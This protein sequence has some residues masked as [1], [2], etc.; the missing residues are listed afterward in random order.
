MIACSQVNVERLLRK[1]LE[2]QSDEGSVVSS[3]SSGSLSLSDDE[4]WEQIRKELQNVG[5]TPRAFDK[6]RTFILQTLEQ[7]ILE[8]DLLTTFESGSQSK[9]MAN[10]SIESESAAALTPDPAMIPQ[11]RVNQ[12]PRRANR[13]D[14]ISKPVTST[15]AKRPNRLSRLVYKLTTSRNKFIQAAADGDL[16]LVMHHLNMDVDVHYHNMDGESALIKAAG[17]GHKNI[18]ELL[19]AQGAPQRA[20]SG[21]S[22][23][24]NTALCRAAEK[25]HERIIELILEGGGMA[26]WCPESS[27]DRPASPLC[28]AASGGHLRAKQVLLDKGASVET[29]HGNGEIRTMLEHGAR[30]TINAIDKNQETPL[31]LAIT[32]G[33]SEAAK[34]L[35]EDGADVNKR[36]EDGMQP[37]LYAARINRLAIVQIL[38]EG[39]ADVK[40]I[41]SLGES[42]LWEAV[43]KNNIRMAELLLKKGA[44][45]NL[46]TNDKNNILQLAVRR[47]SISMASI[48]LKYKAN[49]NQRNEKGETSLFDAVKKDNTGMVE[50]LLQN[51]A[52]ID[53][54]D[55]V[56]DTVLFLSVRKRS[57][58]MVSLLLRKGADP[59]LK[60]KEG[61]S[62]TY[63][64][65]IEFSPDPRLIRLLLGNGADPHMK[66]SGDPLIFHALRSE[67]W[68]FG[69]KDG[70]RDYSLFNILLNKGADSDATDR[71]G[72]TILIAA[73]HKGS[74]WIISL[75]LNHDADVSLQ[76]K[77][78][79]TPLSVWKDAEMPES[80]KICIGSLLKDRGAR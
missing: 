46:K 43:S 76:D 26:E 31:L 11:S 28:V 25:G 10:E 37:L 14:E 78:G 17:N 48:L 16:S 7:A 58:R 23:E 68:F 62:S 44:D 57:F 12:P 47:N 65:T 53:T 8:G 13:N 49:P 38:L 36:V 67:G 50:L 29:L 21:T 18:V 22:L 51:E 24:C 40:S 64:A 41:N 4:A 72:Q 70:S 2:E 77:T 59:N 56:G 19:V 69:L 32:H 3:L 75:L 1:L 15:P 39:R 5:M 34:L 9:Q 33:S 30:A 27:E 66:Y 73:I 42:A 20:C 55:N 35:M 71:N 60:N 6:N 74:Y 52:C 61:F 63:Y 45:P 80:D 79:S 54:Q